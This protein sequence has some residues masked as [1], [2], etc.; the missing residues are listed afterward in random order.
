MGFLIYVCY[1]RMI[2]L[3]VKGK[4]WLVLLYCMYCTQEQIVVF[5][6]V[7]ALF[8]ALV[9]IKTKKIFCMEYHWVK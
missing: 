9:D 3:H 7:C 2:H 5:C 8:N 1:L 4:P 6:F